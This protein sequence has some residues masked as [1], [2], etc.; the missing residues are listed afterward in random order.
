MGC[1]ADTASSEQV[2]A[3]LKIKTESRK[4]RKFA[5]LCAATEELFLRKAST[6]Q[7]RKILRAFMAVQSSAAV[8]ASATQWL[9]ILFREKDPFP[10]F[11]N[12]STYLQSVQTETEVAAKSSPP[13]SVLAATEALLHFN[14]TGYVKSCLRDCH[15]HAEGEGKREVGPS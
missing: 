3:V 1:W 2:L 6:E 14:S 11:S 9:I 4:S 15:L 8:D 7:V 12:R 5:A 13:Q 10:L